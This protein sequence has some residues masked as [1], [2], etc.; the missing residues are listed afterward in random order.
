MTF[1][2]AKK[3]FEIR[4]YYWATSQFEKEI[5]ES[6][7]TLRTFKIGRMW[8]AYQFMQQITKDEQFTLA[9]SQ[10]R[11]VYSD[12]AKILGE[13]ISDEE[14]LLLNKFDKF[15]S[16]LFRSQLTTRGQMRSDLAGQ[17]VKFVSKGKLRKAMEIAFT[18][19]YGSQCVKILTTKEGWNPW[20][21]MKFAGW[22]V[23][24][25]FSFG[26][27]QSIGYDHIIQ[28]EAKVP[29]PE[30]PPEWWMPAMRLGDS[31]SFGS[32]LGLSTHTEWASLLEGEVN[33][34]CDAAI[35]CCGRFFEITPK[36]LNGLE[37]EKIKSE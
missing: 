22:T 6:F 18:K 25:S 3:E 36:L 9:K 11:K 15:C 28:S 5:A 17:K 33:Q 31:L 26:R 20:F 35:K 13:S 29:N 23:I 16:Q 30:V 21:E 37:F 27:N 2:K 14:N 34:A 1:E 32:W 7:P 8:E 10:L 24:T 12:T 19:A 4:Y